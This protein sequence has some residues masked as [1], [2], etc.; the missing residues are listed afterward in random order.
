MNVGFIGLG[1]MGRPMAMNLLNA[2]HKL[3]VH[4]RTHARCAPLQEAGASVAPTPMA[5][6]EATEAVIT[7]V[8]DTPDVESVL[9]GKTGVIE[10]IGSEKI[11]IDMSTISPSATEQFARRLAEKGAHML[12]A[13]VSGGDKGAIAGTLSIMVGGEPEIVQRAKPLFDAMGKNIVHV[14]GNGDGQRTKACNQIAGAVH[15]VAMSE[16]L[17]LARAAGLDCEKV[18]AAISQ[19]AAGSWMMSQLAPRAIK[20]DFDPGFMIRLQAKDLR[21]AVEE[22]DRLG[23]PARGTRLAKELFDQATEM[24]LGELGTQG[25]YKLYQDQLA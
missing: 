25:I 16:A 12:D 17:N 14:G 1:I 2:G 20:N 7:I 18:L 9:F 15:L 22:I 21:L 24:G 4:N 6:A 3:T 19:G 5:V 8:S 10:G 13:P 23:I 11:V